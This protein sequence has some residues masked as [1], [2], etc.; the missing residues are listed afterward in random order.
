MCFAV[1]ARSTLDALCPDLVG[2]GVERRQVQLTRGASLR[3]V[4][5][6]VAGRRLLAGQCPPGRRRRKA[7]RISAGLCRGTEF[8]PHDT[9]CRAKHTLAAPCWTSEVCPAR[10]ES[11]ES[12]RRTRRPEHHCKHECFSEIPLRWDARHERQEGWRAVG[13]PGAMSEWLRGPRFD[14]T[15]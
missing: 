5:C 1:A 11:R 2:D 8:R 15:V 13:A 4:A 3:V 6:P 12:P 7:G 14:S 9:P 10:A